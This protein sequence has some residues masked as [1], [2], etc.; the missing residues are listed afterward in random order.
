MS[1]RS[2]ADSADVV[3]VTRLTRRTLV[4]AGAGLLVAA[5]G[6]RLPP[7]KTRSAETN[8]GVVEL[9]TGDYPELVTPGG[10]VAVK[11]AGMR[12]PVLVMRVEH[13]QVRVL[14]LK[15]P[16]MGC[17]LRW[18]SEEQIL[19]CPCHGS[20]FDDTGQVVG[21]PAKED[22]EVLESQSS[23]TRVQFRLPRS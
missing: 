8:D 20:R 17:V 18:D 9:E 10:M 14:S 5:C 21:G 6:G 1:E 11:P 3:P 15:C 13:E 23:G 7:W 12:K 19:R 16:H 2:G 4:G 22:L